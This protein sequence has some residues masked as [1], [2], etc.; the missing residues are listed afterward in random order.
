MK[1]EIR[2]LDDLK[3]EKGKLLEILDLK[4]PEYEKCQEAAIS[5][6]IT[7]ARRLFGQDNYQ[8]VVNSSIWGGYYRHVENGTCIVA[9]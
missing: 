5:A 8:A 6:M 3:N 9:R 4:T 2:L 7:H 1:I